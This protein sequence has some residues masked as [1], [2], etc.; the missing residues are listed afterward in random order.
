MGVVGG[1]ELGTSNCAE[2]I[3]RE[4]RDG[5]VLLELHK[6]GRLGPIDIVQLWYLLALSLLVAGHAHLRRRLD[7]HRGDT[8]RARVVVAARLQALC[9]HVVP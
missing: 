9:V 3:A 5:L 8:A 2:L 7:Q 1:R 6:H 4:L